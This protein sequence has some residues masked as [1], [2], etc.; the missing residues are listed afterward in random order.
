MYKLGQTLNTLIFDQTLGAL[1]FGTEGV[2]P[3][4]S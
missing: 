3:S 4:E 1:Y 2:E